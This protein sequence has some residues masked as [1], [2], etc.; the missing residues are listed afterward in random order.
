[1]ITNGEELVDL[2]IQNLASWI[3]GEN[4]EG[5]EY[6]R[7]P[8]NQLEQNFKVG[9]SIFNFGSQDQTNINLD[10]DF[11]SFTSNA[12]AALLE[13]DSTVVLESTET[14]TFAVGLYE[15]TYTVSSDNDNPSGSTFAN[16]TYLRNFEVTENLYSLDGIGNH[17]TG[18]QVV[19]SLGTSSWSGSATN[20]SDDQFFMATQYNI[21][22][23]TY[24][25]SVTALFASSSLNCVFKT[26]I[27]G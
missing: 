20:P 19:S 1:M 9:S 2:D 15:G 23:P 3:F 16:N 6:G 4:S 21:L 5:V 7:T 14:P 11:G 18:T 17:P 12:T 25:H 13:A 22:A 10:V 27:F 8:I 26:W 24:M